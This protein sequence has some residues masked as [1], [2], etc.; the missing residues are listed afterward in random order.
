[1]SIL[2]LCA[3]CFCSFAQER[4]SS[5]HV[6]VSSDGMSLPYRIILP[7]N[8][9]QSTSYPLLLFLHGAG[10]RGD[11]NQ[12]QFYNGRK[13]LLESDRLRDVIVIAPQCPADGYWVDFMRFSKY[14]ENMNSSAASY[15][16]ITPAL[17]AVKE[18]LDYVISMRSIDTDR[19]YGI[20]ISMGAMGTLD[21]MCR[22]PD[23]FVAVQPICGAVECVRLEAYSGNTA[24]RLFH[25]TKDDVIPVQFSRDA[26]RTL[27]EK[28]GFVVEYVEYPECRHD[29]WN[30]AFVSEGF[31]DWL[32]SKTRRTGCLL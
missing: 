21:L 26:Y 4:A 22:Y 31:L 19:I 7:D 14:D 29:S 20:G 8:Y 6:F 15:N 32:L 28:D 9:N 10:E 25:G 30:T 23:F 13:M 17:K 18:L 12:S 5:A 2:L 27:S 3:I 11:D 16:E 24:V 1:M